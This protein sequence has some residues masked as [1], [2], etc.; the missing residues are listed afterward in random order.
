M[1]IT[2]I[3]ISHEG[4]EYTYDVHKMTWFVNGAA[5]YPKKVPAEVKQMKEKAI[6]GSVA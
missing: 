4:I 2:S 1:G 3:T 6:A 5:V